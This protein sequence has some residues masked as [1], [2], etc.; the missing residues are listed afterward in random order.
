MVDHVRGE[1]AVSP[2]RTLVVS[3]ALDRMVRSHANFADL[4]NTLLSGGHLAASFVWDEL[5]GTDVC[6]AMLLPAEV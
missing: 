1:L 6:D 4:R 3:T 5:L 2:Q